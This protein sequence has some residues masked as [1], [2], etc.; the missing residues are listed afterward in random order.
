MVIPARWP[1]AS[2]GQCEVLVRGLPISRSLTA[3]ATKVEVIA[4]ITMV[5]KAMPSSI[6]KAA[7]IR[8]SS[9][10]RPVG[11]VDACRDGCTIVP[12]EAQR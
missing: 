12:S 5:K 7:M 10:D 8:P 11:A 2:E 4:A 1:A 6:T 9:S 3:R